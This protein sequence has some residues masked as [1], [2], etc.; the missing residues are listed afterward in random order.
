MKIKIFITLLFLNSM[1]NYAQKSEHI[2]LNW[3]KY[4]IYNIAD[5]NYKI[6]QFNLENQLFDSDRLA[7]TFGAVFNDDKESDSSSL[8][9]SNVVTETMSFNDLGDLPIKTIPAVFSA[10]ILNTKARGVYYT[11][12]TCT[13]IIN[14]NGVLKKI[15]SFDVKYDFKKDFSET[16]FYK[17]KSAVSNSVLSTGNWYKFSLT[18]SGAYKITKSFL[19]Q[20]GIEINTISPK[21]IKIYGNGGRMIPL[22][23]G[24]DYPLDLQEIAIH[25][26]G[27]SNAVFEDGEYFLF[28]GE[29]V[30]VWNNDSATSIN[31][32]DSKSYYYVTINESDS[33]TMGSLGIVSGSPEVFISKYDATQFY[34]QDLINPARLGRKWFGEDFSSLNSRD[35]TFNFPN[36]DLTSRV[37]A[38]T[39]LLS[40]SPVAT[41]FVLNLD[42]VVLGTKTFTPVANGAA[43]RADEEI[44]VSSF[45]PTSDTFV[46]NLKYNNS[47]V[48]SSEGYLDYIKVSATCFLKGYGKQFHFRY[49]LAP[50]TTKIG[51]YK[52]DNASGISEIWDVTDIYNVKRIVNPSQ[53]IFTFTTQLGTVTRYL[54][55][56]NSDVYIPTIESQPYVVNQDI[57]G[58]IFKNAQGNFQDIDYLIVTN[59]SFKTQ[60]DRLADFHKNNSGL[61]VKVVTL[62]EIYTEFS[63]G[64]QDIGAIRNMIKYVYRNASSEENKIKYVCLF[65]GASFDYKNRV[66]NNTNIVPIFHSNVGFSLSSTFVTDD[67]YGLMDDS[68]GEMVLTGGIDIAVG[69]M[70]FSNEAEAA[71][72]VDKVIGYNEKNTFGKWR[73]EMVLISDDVDQDWEA[74]IQQGLDDISKTIAV[75]KSFFNI[76][77]IYA[78]SYKQETTSGGERYPEVRNDIV[79]TVEKGVLI[80]NYFGHGGEDNLAHERI[81]EKKDVLD[82]KNQTKLPLIITATCEFSRFDNPYRPTAGEYAYLNPKGGAISLISTTRQITVP[83]GLALNTS[84]MRNLIS[85]NSTQY[86]TIAEALR[87]TKNATSNTVSNTISY[88][89]DP[90]IKLNIPKSKIILTHINDVAISQTTDTL[91]ALSLIKLR[92]NILDATDNVISGYN[93]IIGLDIFD[94]KIETKTLGNDNTT[95]SG[96]IIIMNFDTLGASIFK[97]NA[98]VKDGIFEVSFVVPKD[99]KAA[100]GNGRISFYSHDD[101]FKNDYTGV[102]TQIKIG[103]FNKNAPADNTPPKV[104]LYINNESFVSGGIVNTSPILIANLE[105]DNGISTAGGIGHDIVAYLDGDETKPII[106]NDYYE[107]NLND[108]KSGKLNYALSNL[109]KGMHTLQFKAWDVYNNA[110][111][112]EIQ[113]VVVGDENLVLDKVLNYPNPFVNYTE[114]WFNHNKPNEPLDVRV[115]IFTITGKLI[116]TINQTV[117]T[118]GFLSRDI[119]WDG[120]DD[121]GDKIGKGVY[122]YK[123]AVKATLSNQYAEKIEKLVVF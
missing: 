65:G 93:G 42:K 35:F 62:N 14:E 24:T 115:Q 54:A 100:V 70:L 16:V 23:N 88:I 60:A 33:K 78:D 86:K 90:A 2:T 11:H 32:Y 13:P 20:L 120:L 116:K 66:P 73:N 52:I 122:V 64:K 45:I 119:K 91:K 31:L 81:L 6:P 97:G 104:K 105:D 15:I 36:L 95:S 111:T 27:N 7:L 84:L 46:L 83:T 44:I 89:G 61:N 113:F 92:G 34:E 53:N 17:N 1:F 79:R 47:G 55:I 77:K 10:S 99:I 63:S 30:D 57:K 108:Y 102:D 67:F 101:I 19:Q 75:E 69:R 106:L 123:L 4:R 98:T 94:K 5:N 58:T 87:L 41:S 121:F 56:D 12:F 49:D 39:N 8:K 118:T 68:E 112:S 107:T 117:F 25:F 38:T 40:A 114:F 76:R 29:G 109:E 103:G 21:A 18:K 80:F 9:I 43:T 96:Q 37:Y 71:V 110:T 59:N 22:L 26:V 50:S 3:G 74:D 48:P 72:V 51:E 82:F 85:Y 28:Y